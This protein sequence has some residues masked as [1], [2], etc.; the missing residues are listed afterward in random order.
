MLHQ[1]AYSA[2][3]DDIKMDWRKFEGAENELQ[4]NI[5]AQ[6]IL[7]QIKTLPLGLEKQG[8]SGGN[9]DPKRVHCVGLNDL[10]AEVRRR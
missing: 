6:W 5:G 4:N 7:I 3:M 9:R 1:Q 8:S 10:S 2:I